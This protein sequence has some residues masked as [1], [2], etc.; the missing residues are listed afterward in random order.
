MSGFALLYP[1]YLL[2]GLIV[3]SGSGSAT[4]SFPIILVVRYAIGVI[5]V[6]SHLRQG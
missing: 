6:C 3:I 1:T 2:F 5:T 4:F